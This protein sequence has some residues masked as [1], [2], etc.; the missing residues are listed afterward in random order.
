MQRRFLGRDRQVRIFEHTDDRALKNP[1]YWKTS[2]PQQESATIW[3]PAILL[4][5]QIHQSSTMVQT[6]FTMR[7]LKPVQLV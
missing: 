1:D 3:L 5:V 2:V 4:N 6:V 7:H